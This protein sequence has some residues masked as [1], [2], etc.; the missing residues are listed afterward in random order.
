MTDQP[1]LPGY[2]LLQQLG[3]GGAGQV[4]AVRRADGV[5]C[6]AKFVADAEGADAA[7][8]HEAALLQ[9]LRHE[10]VVRLYEVV[11][12]DDGAVALVMQL[13]EGGSLA[14][15]LRSRDHLTPGELVTVLC[16]V[17]RAV[18]DLHSM[19]LIHGDLS[20]GN[21]LFTQEGKPLIADLGFAHLAGQD[22]SQVWGTESWA[23]PEVLAGEPLTPAS[24]VYS[25]GA[26][27]WSAVVGNPPE[28]AAFRPSLAD[29]A[30]GLEP[31]LHDLILAC[32][33]HTPHSRPTPEDFALRL[34]QVAPPDPAP[35]Q[36]SPGRRTAG[37][38]P[39]DDPGSALTRRIRDDAQ[40][41]AVG[42]H[43]AEVVGVIPVW[44]RASTLRTVGGAA[45]VG[46]LAGILML[47]GNDPPATAG[48]GSTTATPASATAGRAAQSLRSAATPLDTT[49]RMHRPGNATS[50]AADSPVAVSPQQ[51][52]LRSPA[53]VLQRLVDARARAWTSGRPGELSNSVAPGSTAYR[54]DSADLSTARQRGVRY[55]GLSFRVHEAH[56]LTGSSSTPQVEAT[57]DRS[58]YVAR[59][60]GRSTPV[61]AAPAQ[62]V[63]IALLSTPAG[64]RIVSWTAA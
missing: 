26:I 3:A 57:V 37:P 11:T 51:Q 41:E 17:A 33:S 46:L 34:W 50:S 7:L 21:V 20:P 12:I 38:L 59:E 1:Q 29:V 48:R 49:G 58:G 64:W 45:F 19:G 23:A 5:R 25:L 44:R 60:G 16:P 9:S 22:G 15:S 36:G 18:H 14:D 8:R 28:P 24:D 4:W 61:A 40:R 2:D 52:L 31:E 53:T 55:V 42:R 13:A 39:A 54:A 6:A 63:R 27:A 32:L 62:H 43:R 10:H 47:T 35:V 56:L 30:P